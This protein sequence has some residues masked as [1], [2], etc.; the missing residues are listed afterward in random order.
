MI[1]EHWD[2]KWKAG[3][4]KYYI[5]WPDTQMRQ[6]ELDFIRLQL[7]HLA[8]ANLGPVQKL[9]EIGCGPYTLDED[10][11]L[12]GLVKN[13]FEYSG[14]DNSPAAIAQAKIDQ[15]SLQFYKG[16]VI[17]DLP[18]LV[19]P[20]YGTILSRR[21]LQN[22]PPERRERLLDQVL[23]W[24]H[25]ILVESC[26]A[27]LHQLNMVRACF[28]L[29]PMPVP[30]FNYY[31]NDMEVSNIVSKGAKRVCFSSG[32]YLLTRGVADLKKF[33]TLSHQHYLQIQDVLKLPDFGP[34]M[35]FVW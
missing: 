4:S 1:N 10:A 34:L 3:R 7:R 18:M 31:L 15:P 14:M 9:L 30:E 2:A 23:S 6:L 22:I 12:H 11:L 28:N 25:G 19:Q 33:N 29:A 24:S 27:G 16:D 21:C 8:I 17:I 20:A 13:A 26:E 32:Y 35:G 5:S